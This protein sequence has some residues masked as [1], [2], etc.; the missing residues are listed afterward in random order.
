MARQKGQKKQIMVRT[1]AIV[2][3]VVLAVSVILMTVLK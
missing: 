2:L 1:I 3:A